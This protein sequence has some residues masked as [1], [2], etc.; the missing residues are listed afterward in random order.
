VPEKTA[1]K[2]GPIAGATFQRGKV[3]GVSGKAMMEAAIRKRT[4]LRET[5]RR[6]E[7]EGY[8]HSGCGLFGYK[9]IKHLLNQNGK[10]LTLRTLNC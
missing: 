10:H 1:Q 4:V 3:V 8:L 2:R 7:S 6:K 5:F 9:A